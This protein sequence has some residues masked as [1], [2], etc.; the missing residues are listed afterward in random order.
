MHE[1][2]YSVQIYT[3]ASFAIQY[4]VL[5]PFCLRSMHSLAFVF[6]WI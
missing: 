6:E 5:L 2:V 1:M 4:I 3:P